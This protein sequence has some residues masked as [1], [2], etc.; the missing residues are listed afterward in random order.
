M[1][2]SA[3]HSSLADERASAASDTQSQPTSSMSTPRATAGPVGPVGRRG[4]PVS[5]TR[6]AST[7]FVAASTRAG[8]AGG[9]WHSA[10]ASSASR[11][12]ARAASAAS[13]LL[14][15]GGHSSITAHVPAAAASAQP[16]SRSGM[17]DAGAGTATD[18]TNAR[19]AAV[20]P[21]AK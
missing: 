21:A 16:A 1:V 5:L 18:R 9:S 3:A 17:A 19:M 8:T 11:W 12:Q 20:L 14:A 4:V 13:V 15:R 2:F 7:V 10:S 6:S